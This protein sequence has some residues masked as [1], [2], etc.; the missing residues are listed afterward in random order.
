MGMMGLWN[1]GVQSSQPRM[2][3]GDI[4][5]AKKDDFVNSQGQDFGAERAALGL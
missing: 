2:N 1:G 5:G 3:S 4:F